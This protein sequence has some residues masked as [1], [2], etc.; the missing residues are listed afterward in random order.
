MTVERL[1]GLVTVAYSPGDTL[2]AL[3][4]SVPAASSRPVV[5]VVSDNGSADGSVDAASRRP[6]VQVV[7]NPRN[8]GYG[9]AANAGVAALPPEADPVLIVNPDV[10]LAPGAIDALLSG[11]DRHPD[12][13]A[14][15]PLIS[16]ESGVIY[17]SARR[18]PTIGAGAGHAALGWCWPNNP[19][20][21]QY[22]QDHAAPRERPAG[23]LS[24]SC[25]LVRRSAF[26]AV[27]GFDPGYFMYFEDVDLGRR[28]RQAGY[29]SYYIPD[30][31]V[32]HHGG[33]S[34]RR[35][36]AEM[37]RA[38]HDSAYRYLAGLYDA[39]WQAPLRWAL[40]G[41]LAVRAAM[42]VRSER[43]A[44]GAELPDCRPE[45]APRGNH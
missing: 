15:G 26:A 35:H 44:G 19:W 16:T 5:A 20:T 25:L 17:P 33:H 3:L 40:R 30:A 12:A 21:V 41:G 6:N 10:E 37:V 45:P 36:R 24:G 13:G 1:L 29:A 4:D 8:L 42:A 43:V 22:R 11:L 23:W 28:L 39:R 27:G 18:L 2:A 31:R 34:T 14:V 32:L 38:H 9:G 7:R